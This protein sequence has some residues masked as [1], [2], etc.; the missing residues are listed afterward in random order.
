VLDTNAHYTTLLRQPHVGAIDIYSALVNIWNLM[1]YQTVS[2]Y[3]PVFKLRAFRSFGKLFI[4]VGVCFIRVMWGQLRFVVHQVFG[5]SGSPCR[6]LL[7]DNG[8]F[9]YP[10]DEEKNDSG[11]VSA[12]TEAAPRGQKFTPSD[13]GVLQRFVEGR[14]GMLGVYKFLFPPRPLPFFSSGEMSSHTLARTAHTFNVL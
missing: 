5:E 3:W 14:R 8:C 12:A 10:M 13:Y 11:P 7:G 2:F 1:C 9:Y 6:K 4:D